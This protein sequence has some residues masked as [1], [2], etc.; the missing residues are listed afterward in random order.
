MAPHANKSHQNPF[1]NS[2]NSGEPF[3]L[4]LH[5]IFIKKNEVEYGCTLP[6]FGF[7][8]KLCRVEG[9]SIV[10]LKDGGVKKGA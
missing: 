4:N 7:K 2:F 9:A 8:A 1:R 10:Y 6:R 3:S 5:K